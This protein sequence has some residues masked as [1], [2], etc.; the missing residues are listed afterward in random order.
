MTVRIMDGISQ[1]TQAREEK[2][3]RSEERGL[4]AGKR[5]T[6]RLKVQSSEFREDI[7]PG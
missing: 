2:R 7:N 5:W 6:K 3:E 1:A 4:I